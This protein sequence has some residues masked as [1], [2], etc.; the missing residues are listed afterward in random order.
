MKFLVRSERWSSGNGRR[1]SYVRHRD[2][3][4][5]KLKKAICAIVLTGVCHGSPVVV[6]DAS[7][8]E[9]VEVNASQNVLLWNDV[10]GS[11][12]DAI[13]NNASPVF[14]DP[15]RLGNGHLGIGISQSQSGG[16]KL[17]NALQADTLLDFS[18]ATNRPKGFSALMAVKLKSLPGSTA[19]V[20]GNTSTPAGSGFAIQL[21]PSGLLTASLGTATVSSSQGGGALL[22]AGD[23]VVI[24]VVYNGEAQK[25]SIYESRNKQVQTLAVNRGDFGIGNDLYFG[26]ATAAGVGVSAVVGEVQL[27]ERPLST[28]QLGEETL[29]MEQ[30]WVTGSAPIQHLSVEDP[31]DLQTSASTLT[32]WLDRSGSGNNASA[33]SGSMLFPGTADPATGVRALN[34][35]TGSE[36]LSLFNAAG[37]DTWLN[38]SGA[39][40][41]KSG[42]TV[43]LAFKP[44]AFV[45]DWNDLLGNDSDFPNPGFV[46][47]T[48]STGQPVVSLGGTD[49]RASTQ[50][51]AGD[52]VFYAVRY[53]AVAGQYLFWN[54]KNNETLLRTLAAGDFSGSMPLRLGRSDNAGRHFQGDFLETKIFDS[55]IS[56]AQ[57]EQEKAAM[58]AK[59]KPAVLPVEVLGAEGTTEERQF[60]LD[61]SQLSAAEDL[62]FQVNSLTYQDK[63]SIR[64]NDEPWLP[65]NHT[66]TVVQAQ[67][68]AR[69]GMVHGGF[70]TIRF[71]IPANGLREGLNRIQ[72]RF[73]ES[74][75]ISIGYR[76]V[77][78]N[79]LD[80]SGVKLLPPS[81]FAEDDP[82]TWQAP[83]TD[84]ASIDE[85]ERI[86]R[87]VTD[88]VTKA[89]GGRGRQL[90]NHYKAEGTNGWWYGYDLPVRKTIQA[91]CTDCHTQDG[92][93]LEMFSYSNRSIIERSKFHNLTTLEGQKVA[94]YIRSLS[95]RFANVDRAGRP[96]NPPY[97]PGPSVA[98]R[99]IHEWAAG[100]GLDAVLDNDSDMAPYLFP[101]GMGD[102]KLDA[103]FDTD[104]NYDSTLLPL[105]IQFPDW[106]HW[107]PMVHPMDAF[108]GDTYTPGVPIYFDDNMPRNPRKALVDFRNYLLT[109]PT[110]P[111][112]KEQFLLTR[113]GEY[114]SK[115]TTMN[116]HFRFFFAVG[117]VD[118]HWRSENGLAQQALPSDMPREFAA[119]SLS[120]LLSVRNFEWANEFDLQDKAH[121]FTDFD[122]ID[123]PQPRQ[124]ISSAF[125]VYPVGPHF[126]A[127]VEEV[128]KGQQI[129][130]NSRNFFGQSGATG[131]YESTNWYEIQAVLNAGQARMGGRADPVDYNYQQPLIVEA[132][133]ESG[134]LEP[135]RYM[136]TAARMYQTKIDSRSY[137]PDDGSGFL[138]RNMGPWYLFPNVGSS[139]LA[140][141][142]KFNETEPGLGTRMVNAHLRQFNEEM[143]K[144]GYELEDWMRTTELP[145]GS[146]NVSN[147]LDDPGTEDFWSWS[148][149]FYE[150]IPSFVQMGTDPVELNSLLS[151]CSRAWPYISW[152]A[153]RNQWYATASRNSSNASRALDGVIGTRWDTGQSQANGQW[154]Q[155]D[156]LAV[157]TFD[158]I[159]L[160]QGSSSGDWPRGYRIN[161]SNDG[162]NW[163]SAV[164]TGVGTSGVTTISF[165]TRSA[166]YIRITQT[167]SNGGYWSI[168]ELGLYNAGT[169][170]APG[171]APTGLAGAITQPRQIDLTW[172]PSTGSGNYNIKRSTNPGGPYT[173]IAS[174][175]A[176]TSYVDAGLQEGTYYH[177]VVSQ[178]AGTG[179]SP[180]SIELRMMTAD[181]RLD[182]SGWVASASRNS[183]TAGNAIDRT[184]ETRWTTG[185]G[186]T[187]G[188]WFRLDMLSARSFNRIT[189][190]QGSSVSEWP[191]GYQIHVSN[192][193]TNWGSVIASGAGATGLI[194]IDFPTQSARYIRIT[195]TASN[196]SN[197][198]IHELSV[199]NVGVTVPPNATPTGLL[200]TAIYHKQIDL[201]WQP[202]TGS[203]SYNV[204][205]STNPGG[206]YTLIASNVLATSYVD[207]GL[208]GS[209]SYYYV[210]SQGSGT[211]ESPNSAELSVTT[212][213]GRLDQ[214]GWLASASRN[215]SN[216]G[217][218][219][220][221]TIST[222]W[223]TGQAQVP[224]QWFQLDMLTARTFDKI[225]LDQGT[226]ANDWPR[227]YQVHVS[228]DGINWGIPVATGV[229]TSGITTIT[230]AP[231]SARYIRIT[232]TGTV[233]GLYWSIHEL[234]IHH[235]GAGA[236]SNATPTGLV[237]SATH[238]RQIDLAW[239]PAAGSGS[240]NIKRSA[241]QGGPYT[242]IASN[243]LSTSY[244]DTGLEPSTYYHYVVSQ[245]TGT[246]ESPNSAELRVTTT[247]GRL[248][249]TG[250][251]A[252]ASRNTSNAGRAIDRTISTRWDTA[253][254]QR[255]GQW[256]RLDMLAVRSFNRI[257]LDQGSSANDWPR[258]Y[259]IHVSNDGVNWGSPIV[260]GTGAAG[261]VTIDFPTQSAR[262]IRITQT[263]TVA[264]LYW[265]IHELE[266]YN[267]QPPPTQPSLPVGMA[268]WIARFEVTDQ[269]QTGD[270]DGDGI[271][272]L[273]EFLFSATPP[274]QPL[275]PTI[276]DSGALNQSASVDVSGHMRLH[277]TVPNIFPEGLSVRVQGSNDLINWGPVATDG[278]IDADNGDGTSTRVWTQINPTG[279]DAAMRFMRAEV[280]ED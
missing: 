40:S 108:T 76:V 134:V 97:Q 13:P 200:A 102:D 199:Y 172:Q 223:D 66:T 160:D 101:N 63:G 119:T 230:F 15:V 7:S 180:D 50:I 113:R 216:A 184:I 116:G 141:M 107:L 164:A 73:D 239:Q 173:L 233:A 105:A 137:A 127:A 30:K 274:F 272:N 241:T 54:S 206:P 234:S 106:K 27:F 85:G 245:G 12:L 171:G 192:D 247:D 217:R 255:P 31:A 175:V 117:T 77:R 64:I 131:T 38:F 82:S 11:N 198:S 122:A 59:W 262:Y 209:T 176:S 112:A 207:T 203:G 57:L 132:C 36:T 277:L 110:D 276:N 240:Y 254:T 144:P 147:V 270:D 251:L 84:Q 273:W 258:G 139:P 23:T 220:D 114:L 49:L 194:T 155:L 78:F 212:T 204:K 213:N 219:I 48:S 32:S 44:S 4:R 179:E 126:Q 91:A 166:R 125:A 269:T 80:A 124:W 68:M 226:S 62:W 257:T 157:R 109:M 165:G 53:D 271:A 243:V 211:A 186:Q 169:K 161:V 246:G 100:A 83:F 190:N 151:W 65:L 67:E 279:S 249:S 201:T 6:L 182:A 123:H 156:L 16:F 21:A 75:T 138:I 130:A 154:F 195:Q 95:A 275:D 86:W 250:W 197:W 242:L 25:L 26:R 96:W 28:A 185:Q 14:P 236:P 39:A 61:A 228:N 20:M 35:R 260:S 52:T 51:T 278:G 60:H 46:M 47:R 55:K 19:A 71:K 92:R 45:A 214:T 120:R 29:R 264:G 187:S 146:Q 81:R 162:I 225:V 42:F 140:M 221:L 153:A 9:S 174:N 259:E 133:Q 90:W 170:L 237:A 235:L 159:V 229:G 10:S 37:Q 136:H 181:G 248:D 210:V 94:S 205:R 267:I 5:M 177:Y 145:E 280:I 128:Y 104:G 193:G 17:L 244:V 163:G 18:V 178:G 256:F 43:L 202:A 143:R 103:L 253:E 150:A 79:V 268:G 70:N 231:Q 87:G 74:D 33:E 129:P 232:Q 196:S 215:T 265:S 2:G 8:P 89:Q 149:R 118:E 111:A 99:P 183:S 22:Q 158:R 152:E 263:G 238:H 121:L 261:L 222:R 56:E 189:L 135:F 142:A 148:S 88:L 115:H 168:H 208:E 218:A 98:S 188:Q 224:G 252:S 72:F 93:D 69:G 191:R 58:N 266:V 1:I 34:A 3:I 41:G 24:A 167:G 227:G